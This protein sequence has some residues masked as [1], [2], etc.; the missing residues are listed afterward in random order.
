MAHASNHKRMPA[1]E[2]DLG[3]SHTAKIPK[4]EPDLVQ[5]PL[6]HHPPNPNN[7]FSGS[8]KKRL[9]TSSRT[10]QACDRC[11]VSHHRPPDPPFRGQHRACPPA[12]PPP[13]AAITAT[14]ATT[15]VHHA[16][17]PRCARYDATR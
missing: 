8:V 17:R 6:L 15:T 10:G 4:I 16:D 11:K 13:T 14:T 1:S 2:S 12:S 3:L 9:A 5:S 7:D